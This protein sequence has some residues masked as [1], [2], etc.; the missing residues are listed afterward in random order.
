MGPLSTII[1]ITHR[2]ALF[3]SNARTHRTTAN[4]TGNPG[5]KPCQD[6]RHPD[7][8]SLRRITL[9]KGYLITIRL[10][11]PRRPERGAT[12]AP[13][14]PRAARSTAGSRRP[15]V[16]P[17]CWPSQTARSA[18]IVRFLQHPHLCGVSGVVE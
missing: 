5:K 2:T 18:P 13:E 8:P 14:R 15:P 17:R 7:G 3:Y 6:R 4:D 16:A 11:K 9:L 10:D 12:V 1:G